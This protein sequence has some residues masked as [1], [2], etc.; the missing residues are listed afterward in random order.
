MHHSPAAGPRSGHA[1]RSWSALQSRYVPHRRSRA[2]FFH[3][4]KP[5]VHFKLDQCRVPCRIFHHFNFFICYI[6]SDINIHYRE[7]DLQSRRLPFVCNQA[8]MCAQVRNLF[9]LSPVLR[10]EMIAPLGSCRFVPQREVKSCSCKK[11]NFQTQFSC[12]FVIFYC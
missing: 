10:F 4:Q 11:K 7:G 6:I 12:F 1:L 8:G 9:L 2:H 5:R 3:S